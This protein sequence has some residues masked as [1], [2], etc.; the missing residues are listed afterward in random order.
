MDRSDPA[1][2]LNLAPNNQLSLPKNRYQ[3]HSKIE[4]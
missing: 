2:L 3:H 1:M 4:L